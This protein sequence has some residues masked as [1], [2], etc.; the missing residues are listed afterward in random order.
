[1]PSLLAWKQVNNRY[2]FQPLLCDA[3]NVEA[4]VVVGSSK[5]RDGAQEI[6]E[7]SVVGVYHVYH[8]ITTA[9]V[10]LGPFARV[11]H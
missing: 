8:R 10:H 7:S 9:D 4:A 11:L 5:R 2:A 3:R 1:M 6:V